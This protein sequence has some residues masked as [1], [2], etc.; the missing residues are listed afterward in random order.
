MNVES[1][2][3][4]YRIRLLNI[5]GHNCVMYSKGRYP[6]YF[7]IL[8]RDELY[9]V[10]CFLIAYLISRSHEF[11]FSTDFFLGLQDGYVDR[12]H[13]ED[14]VG[15]SVLSEIKAEMWETLMNESL[16]FLFPYKGVEI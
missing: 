7:Y 14:S 6:C 13:L 3:R 10:L 1:R 16:S 2:C 4:S 12:Y 11:Q 5:R 15:V 9:L 8:I